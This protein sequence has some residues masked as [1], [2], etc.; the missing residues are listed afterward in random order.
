[1][2]A[3]VGMAA[4]DGR[5]MRSDMGATRGAAMTN[6]DA[7]ADAEA[8]AEAEAEVDEDAEVDE[9]HAGTPPREKS[10]SS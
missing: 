5:T 1:M 2:R 6:A 3:G 9:S 7:D 4:L 8:E 10:L